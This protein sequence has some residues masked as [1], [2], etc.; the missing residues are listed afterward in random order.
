MTDFKT[1]E[2]LDAYYK[3]RPA[4]NAKLNRDLNLDEARKSQRNRVEENQVL[5]Y[6]EDM[7]VEVGQADEEN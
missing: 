4:L 3:Q 5:D 1:L 2:E 6:E 7:K